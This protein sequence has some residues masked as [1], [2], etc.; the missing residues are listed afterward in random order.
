MAIDRKLSDWQAADLIDAATAEAIAAHEATE[1]RPIAR[2]AAIA[3]GLLALALGLTLVVA[4]NWDAIPPMVKLGAHAALLVAA[5]VTVWWT[6]G[7]TRE[8]ALFLFASLVLAGLALVG[9]VY[10]L[11]G[12]VHGLLA[13]AGLLVAPAILL[14]GT[15]RLTAIAWSLLLAAAAIAYVGEVPRDAGIAG[16]LPAALP[17]GLIL[18]SYLVKDRRAFALGLRD[19]GLVLLLAG[20]SLVHFGWAVRISQPDALDMALRLPPALLVAAVAFQLARGG[21]VIR[22]A[23]AAA[24]IAVPLAVAVP[25]ADA[26]APRL[27]GAVLFLAMW[28]VIARAAGEEGRRTLF[29]LAIGAI[30]LRL[31]IIYFELFGSLASTGIGLIGGGLLLIALALAWGRIVRRRAP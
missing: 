10:Q 3:I 7:W 26:T 23:L 1:A 30:A 17:P 25:H 21:A 31:F 4:A 13:A 11:S 6:Q 16:T 20:A 27:I 8:G 2:W 28:A 19:T 14:A 12:S 5:A 15:T 24:A 18:L 9:Q 29:S 22:T